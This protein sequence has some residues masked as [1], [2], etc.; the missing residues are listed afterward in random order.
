MTM[1]KTQV[2]A[3]LKENRNERGIAHWKRKPRRLK[4]FGIGLTQ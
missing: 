1:T 2:L 4:S 3:L